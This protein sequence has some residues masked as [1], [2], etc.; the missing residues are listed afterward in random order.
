MCIAGFIFPLIQRPTLYLP[1]T[2]EAT[3]GQAS[4]EL[5]TYFQPQA[6]RFVVVKQYLPNLEAAFLI[7]H[8]HG[9]PQNRLR[10]VAQDLELSTTENRHS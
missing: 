2:R 10:P 8:N 3:Q 6:G 4:Q 5:M 1:L 7:Q 9:S